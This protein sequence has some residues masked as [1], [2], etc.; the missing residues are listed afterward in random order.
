MTADVELTASLV[1]LI[2]AVPELAALVVQFA[3]QGVPLPTQLESLAIDLIKAGVPAV[4]E[5]FKLWTQSLPATAQSLIA[6]GKFAHL[7]VLAAN[8]VY[9][10]IL[11]PIAPFAVVLMNALP[12]PFGTQGGVINEFLKLSIQTPFLAGTTVLTLLAQTIDDGLSPVAAAL[13]TIDAL[14]TA[15]A[16]AVESIEKIAAALGGALPISLMAAPQGL[17]E[18]RTMAADLPAVTDANVYAPSVISSTGAVDT[19]TVTIEPSALETTEDD[20]SPPATTAEDDTAA[21]EDQS[22]TATQ[23]AADVMPNGATD[24]SGGNMAQPGSINDEAASPAHA[25]V[26][27]ATTDR[28][29]EGA[30]GEQKETTTNSSTDSRTGA[31]DDE[32]SAGE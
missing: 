8:T 7:A 26:T 19:V 32:D 30:A 29:V 15:V 20:I 28:T 18:A 24:L 13:G 12:L 27:D 2:A 10:G 9:S 11:T 16:S 17:D 1:D 4:T 25:D 23:D 3:L 5:T 22:E 31:G 14:F 21:A 6:A